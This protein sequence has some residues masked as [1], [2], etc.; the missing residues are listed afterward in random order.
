MYLLDTNVV[1]ELR[2]HARMVAWLR[3]VTD[4][5]LQM[6]AVTIGELQADVALTREQ[7]PGRAVEIVAWLGH[8]ADSYTHLRQLGVPGAC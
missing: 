8:V 1:W 6:A 2:R 3:G 5:D 4:A 7:D